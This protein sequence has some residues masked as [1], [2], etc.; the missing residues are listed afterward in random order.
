M[1]GVLLVYRGVRRFVRVVRGLG[2]RYRCYAGMSLARI[3]LNQLLSRKE[4][5]HPDKQS[6]LNQQQSEIVELIVVR[7]ALALDVS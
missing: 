5:I 1:C 7:L 2:V 6:Q 4:V 3:Q